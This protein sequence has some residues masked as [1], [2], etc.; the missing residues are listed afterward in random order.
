MV[1][2]TAESVL[3]V[4]KEKKLP[5]ETFPDFVIRLKP[6]GLGQFLEE[7]LQ[8]KRPRPMES[9][10]EMMPRHREGGLG[11]DGPKPIGK[12]EEWENRNSIL[13]DWGGETV[14]VFKTSQGFRACQNVCPH[15]GGS[16]GEGNVE[17]ETVTCPLHG[18][19]FNLQTG[20]CL[21]EPGNDIKI[22]PVDVRKGKVFLHP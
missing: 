9:P 12:E 2:P 15:A 1:F 18:W 10:I 4:F 3:E 8:T 21:N 17:G 7:R 14:A 16:L 22:Y 19:Q 6:E 13:V 20:A 5:E 11:Q